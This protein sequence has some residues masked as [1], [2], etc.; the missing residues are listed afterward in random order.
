MGRRRLVDPTDERAELEL[1][2]GW[3]AQVE[4]ERVL[5]ALVSSASEEAVTSPAGFRP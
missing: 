1:L 3:P 4:Y 2:L 5:P